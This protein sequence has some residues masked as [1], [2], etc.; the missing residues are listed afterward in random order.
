MM[1]IKS[2]RCRTDNRNDV[3]VFVV[4]EH[5][6]MMFEIEMLAKSALVAKRTTTI[7]ALDHC[8]WTRLFKPAHHE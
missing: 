8:F 6:S 3:V 2:D 4:I 7:L 5:W 1:G